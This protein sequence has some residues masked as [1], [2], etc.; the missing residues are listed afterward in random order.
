MNEIKNLQ[1][2]TKEISK[3]LSNPV[4]EVSEEILLKL[5]KNPRI[6]PIDRLN[7]NELLIDKEIQEEIGY[8]KLPSGGWLVAMV[9]DMP[10]VKGEMINWWMWWHA[11]E[12]I[13]YQIWLPGEHVA[14]STDPKDSGHF[15]T[16]FTDFSPNTQ[17][18]VEKIGRMKLKLSIRFVEPAEFGFD[19]NLFPANKIETIVCGHVGVFH[20]KLEHTEMCHVYKKHENGLKLT[21]RF[22]MGDHVHFINLKEK[23]L[24]NRIT[25]KIARKMIFN[26]NQ[27][28]NMAIHCNREYHNLALIL[29]EIFQKYRIK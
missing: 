4:P 18:P 22:W 9:T 2:G 25:G 19:T 14:I 6:T 27:A 1:D 15:S 23:G 13:R 17:Y 11:Q 26:A 20:G 10:R 8:T 7:I 12:S 3:Y 28:F 21:S 29:P 16:P 5:T 24:I